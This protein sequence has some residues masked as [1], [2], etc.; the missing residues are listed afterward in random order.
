MLAGGE[1]PPLFF[2]TFP[3]PKAP[4]YLGRQLQFALTRN[5]VY[6]RGMRLPQ[7]PIADQFNR[8]AL[9]LGDQFTLAETNFQGSAANQAI[10]QQAILDLATALD[11][12]GALDTDN[13]ALVAG[14]ISS[15]GG[16]AWAPGT[17]IPPH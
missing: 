6:T 10:L 15:L 16:D 17:I 9:G 5:L 13:T 7:L 2:A 11:S 1:R 8:L 3:P 4:L 12:L 14:V